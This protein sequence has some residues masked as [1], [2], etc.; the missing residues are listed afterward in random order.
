MAPS[1]SDVDRILTLINSKDINALSKEDYDIFM[2]QGFDPYKLLFALIELKE[3]KAIDDKL[4]S[5]DVCKMVA[6][7]LIKGN[8]NE[9]NKTKMSETGQK[10][11]TTLMSKYDIKSGGGKGKP[12][13]VITFPRVMATFPDIA[14]RLTKVLGGKEFRGGPFKSYL[15]PDCMK[16]QVFPSVIP[17]KLEKPVKSFFLTA[18]LCYSVDQTIQISNIDKPNVVDLCAT[19]FPFVNI[20]HT[21]PLP[22]QDTRRQVFNQLGL[23]AEYANLLSVVTEYK[24]TVDQSVVIPTEDDYKKA[25]AII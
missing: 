11:L 16:I 5:D 20:S 22:K 6:I 19:Q 3:S 24:S 10:D 17:D 8:V 7:G 13:H 21:S 23:P 9:H 12:A 4:F 15:L 2:Y 1:T 18:A 14:V 25:L